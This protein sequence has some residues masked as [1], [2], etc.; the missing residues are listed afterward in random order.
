[1]SAGGYAQRYPRSRRPAPRTLQGSNT[2]P[3]TRPHSPQKPSPP[4][5]LPSQKPEPRVSP[6]AARLSIKTFALPLCPTSPHQSVLPLHSPPKARHGNARPSD[7]SP[8]PPLPPRA[9]GTLAHLHQFDSRR[10]LIRPPTCPHS[11][12]APD[13]VVGVVLNHR[14]GAAPVSRAIRVYILFQYL[15]DKS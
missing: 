10:F 3:P 15:P 5:P 1:M 2:R 11:Q 13:D 12:L 6:T 9:A 14:L 4:L 7:R 8:H